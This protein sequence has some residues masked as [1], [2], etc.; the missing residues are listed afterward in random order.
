M[1]DV[2]SVYMSTVQPRAYHRQ[3]SYGI[4]ISGFTA[5]NQPMVSA[6]AAMLPAGGITVVL[7]KNR[8]AKKTGHKLHCF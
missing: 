5:G 3:S 7:L 6:S 1:I 4:S 2:C 8:F